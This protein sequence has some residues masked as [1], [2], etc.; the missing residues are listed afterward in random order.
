MAQRQGHGSLADAS[1]GLRSLSE[2]EGV[3][4]SQK[5]RKVGVGRSNVFVRVEPVKNV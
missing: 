5:Q 4:S 2:A 1:R 3:R